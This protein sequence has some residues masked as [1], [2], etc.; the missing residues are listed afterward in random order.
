MF[1]ISRDRVAGSSI[2]TCSTRPA[3]RSPLTLVIIAT[4]LLRA[5]GQGPEKAL[6]DLAPDW[7][8]QVYAVNTTG[9]VDTALSRPFQGNVQSGRLFDPERAALQL[10]DVIEGLKVPDSGKPFDFEGEEI[11]F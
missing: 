10:L 4:G 2:S 9:T 8:A 6:R 1:E 7:L 11:P 5:D 3:S